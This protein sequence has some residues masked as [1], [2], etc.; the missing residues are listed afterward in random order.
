M[1][2]ACDECGHIPLTDHWVTNG[3]GSLQRGSEQWSSGQWSEGAVTL[4]AVGSYPLTP[5]GR[6]QRY[7]DSQ[8]VSWMVTMPPMTSAKA[9][10]PCLPTGQAVSQ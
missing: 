5:A 10:I 1:V 4:A 2:T 9:S 8:V 6:G 7:Q 3:S